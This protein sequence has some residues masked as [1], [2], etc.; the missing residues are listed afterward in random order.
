MQ[1]SSAPAHLPH[2]HGQALGPRAL[3]DGSGNALTSLSVGSQRSITVAVVDGS[4]NQITS[5]GGSGGTASNFTSAFPS[6]GTASGFTDGTNMQAGH[7]FDTQQ[8]A[9]E[10]N[11]R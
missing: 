10:P 8:R 1:P 5:F 11:T 4:G 6:A 7:V 9:R 3:Q 2:A